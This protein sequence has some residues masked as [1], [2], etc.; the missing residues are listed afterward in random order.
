[1]ASFCLQPRSN[2][3]LSNIDQ[4]TQNLGFTKTLGWWCLI[5][6]GYIFSPILIDSW[7][8]WNVACL[9]IEFELCPN[10]CCS[11]SIW[12][13]SENNGMGGKIVG[14][15]P[16]R[17]FHYKLLG[18]ICPEHTSNMEETDDQDEDGDERNGLTAKKQWLVLQKSSFP[19]ANIVTVSALYSALWSIQIQ[20]PP[21]K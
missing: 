10:K 9:K 7:C 16:S 14:S 3:L 17:L 1:M 6:G 20:I 12:E 8:W 11:P 5:T 21:Q 2:W 15:V 18:G 13:E 4:A 19:C